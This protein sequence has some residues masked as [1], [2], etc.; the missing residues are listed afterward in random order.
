MIIDATK[1]YKKFKKNKKTTGLKKTIKQHLLD[2]EIVENYFDKLDVSYYEFSQNFDKFLDTV[3][4]YVYDL[5]IADF[6]KEDILYY[7]TLCFMV[8]RKDVMEGEID[9]KYY[10]MYDIDVY[11]DLSC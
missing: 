1:Y 10:R 2:N 7:E 6:K 8:M 11:M 9:G 5:I 3:T 4:G